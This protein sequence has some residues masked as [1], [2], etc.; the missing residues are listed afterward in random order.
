MI[1]TTLAGSTSPAITTTVRSGRYQRSWNAFSAAGVAARNA[2]TDPMGSCSAKGWPAK[3][4][5]R[6]WS[7]TRVEGPC[8]SR[9]SA[10]TTLVSAAVDVG[11]NEGTA[12]IPAR[13]FRL[14]SMLAG[15]AEGRSSL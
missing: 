4:S 15:C 5:S 11:S 14:S 3:N 1:G 10:S 8:P 9:S 7:L 2:S 12:I 13:I 6:N